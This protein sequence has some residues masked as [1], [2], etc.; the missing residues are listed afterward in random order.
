MSK[1]KDIGWM[2]LTRGYV[3]A[4]AGHFGGMKA[5]AVVGGAIGGPFGAFV[6]AAVG[7]TVGSIAGMTSGIKKSNTEAAASILA[8]TAGILPPGKE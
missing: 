5:G 3:M 1:K 7:S 6:G 2:D 4:T 8:T